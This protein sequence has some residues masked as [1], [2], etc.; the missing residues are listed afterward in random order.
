MENWWC[1]STLYIKCEPNVE[2]HMTAHLNSLKSLRMH[3]HTYTCPV[4]R[5][6]YI[7]I[8]TKKLFCKCHTNSHWPEI[9]LRMM[10]RFI[11]RLRLNTC[12]QSSSNI[13]H[14]CKVRAGTP[15]SGTTDLILDCNVQREKKTCGSS[16]LTS[17]S[18][19]VKR[20]LLLAMKSW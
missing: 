7:K 8:L 10:G 9:M 20:R 12:S 19:T 18:M 3:T 11:R 14:G 2:I 16:I 6:A 1:L 4:S 13:E 5:S 15:I 17:Y